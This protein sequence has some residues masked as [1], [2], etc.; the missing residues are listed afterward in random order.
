M[1]RTASISYLPYRVG[2]VHSMLPHAQPSHTAPSVMLA[3][4]AQCR[5]RTHREGP[6]VHCHVGLA[7]QLQGHVSLCHALDPGRG[8]EHVLSLSMHLERLT[9]CH[10]A[11]NGARKRSQ[12]QQITLKPPIRTLYGHANNPPTH[13][14]LFIGQCVS[15]AV[16]KRIPPSTQMHGMRH[17]AVA[18][19]VACR[20]RARCHPG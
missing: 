16:I 6:Y 5:V 1:N 13:M 14:R 15:S 20:T 2:G 3:S 4:V 10:L 17:G 12:Y 18:P 7:P 19:S 11:F 9:P 8:A